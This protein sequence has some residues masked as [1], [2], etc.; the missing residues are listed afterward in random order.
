MNSSCSYNS[1]RSDKVAKKAK[2]VQNNYKIEQR[3][4][5]A[6]DRSDSFKEHS[7]LEKLDLY[8]LSEPIRINAKWK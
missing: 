4:K 1:N 2:I 3:T 5:W 7:S 8:K 6:D